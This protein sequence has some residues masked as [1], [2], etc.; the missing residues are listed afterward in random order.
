[1]SGIAAFTFKGLPSRVI[2]GEGTLA[3][4]GA[5]ISRLGRGRALVLSTPGHAAAA[6]RLAAALGALAA[7]I[8]AGAVMHTP[9][10]VTEAAL[11]AYASGGA[12]CLVATRRRLDDRA[13]QGDRAADRPADQVAIPTTYA[14]SEMTDILGETDGG[15]QDHPAAIRRSCRRR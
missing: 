10:E 9:V 5:E 2:F 13:R 14:G 7:G 6:E 15:A 1:M 8:F 4:V 11:A 12:D 3:E